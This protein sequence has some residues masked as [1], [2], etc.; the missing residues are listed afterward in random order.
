VNSVEGIVLEGFGKDLR[1]NEKI[2]KAYPG[3]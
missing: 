2:K 1:Q 3:E